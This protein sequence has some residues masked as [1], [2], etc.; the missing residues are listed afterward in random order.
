[1]F[2]GGAFCTPELRGCLRERDSRG[3]E[4]DVVRNE[5]AG[6]PSDLCWREC[7]KRRSHILAP[8]EVINPC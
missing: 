2:G 5:L 8:C 7:R 4:R 3:F 1:M 6:L